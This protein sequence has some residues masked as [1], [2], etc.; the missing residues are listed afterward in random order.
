MHSCGWLDQ[1]PFLF[2]SAKNIEHVYAG[3]GVSCR[4]ICHTLAQR[5]MEREKRYSHK[6]II[7]IKGNIMGRIR[8]MGLISKGLNAIGGTLTSHNE[9]SI[10]MWM[11]C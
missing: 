10:F 11:L 4:D 1:P 5:K 2:G 9:K 3:L 8:R 7:N 6:V